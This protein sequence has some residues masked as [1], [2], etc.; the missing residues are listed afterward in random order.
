MVKSTFMGLVCTSVTTGVPGDIYAPSLML[1][2]PMMP[3]NGARI[4]VFSNCAII[5]SL[6]ACVVLTLFIAMSYSS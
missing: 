4:S 6:S 1:F 2:R 3:L 5:R